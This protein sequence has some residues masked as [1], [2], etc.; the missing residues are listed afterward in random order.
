M[1]VV[2]CIY[3]DQKIVVNHG[4]VVQVAV[5]VDEVDI[6]VESEIRSLFW[7]AGRRNI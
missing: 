5:L 4:L 3:G 2:D 6:V 7:D 1:I